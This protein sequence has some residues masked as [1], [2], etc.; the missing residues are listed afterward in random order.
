M[1][2]N[3]YFFQK[4]VTYI[5]QHDRLSARLSRNLRS[6]VDLGLN[7]ESNIPVGYGLGS[8]GALVAAIYD[9]FFTE[10]ASEFSELKRDL[11]DL[12]SFFMKKAVVLTP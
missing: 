12:E 9:D 1:L 2:N 8:S 5:E 11:A 3:K 7:F 10:K 4:L 6:E